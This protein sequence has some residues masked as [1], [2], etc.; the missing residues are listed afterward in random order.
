MK[1]VVLCLGF[2]LAC[3]AVRAE[4]GARE[5]RVENGRGFEAWTVSVTPTTTGTWVDLRY[6]QYNGLTGEHSMRALRFA[7]VDLDTAIAALRRFSVWSEYARR[8]RK[9]D[10]DRSLN[11]PDGATWHVVWAEGKGTLLI[12]TRTLSETDSRHF[13]ALLLSVPEMV[14]ELH[15]R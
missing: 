3:G 2:C 5:Y 15:R 12:G 7:R 8:H 1:L 14:E 9:G 11:G 6:D 10:F 13:R 4:P